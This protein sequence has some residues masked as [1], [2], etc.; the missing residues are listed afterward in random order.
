MI[1]TFA[2]N[3]LISESQVLLATGM[4]SPDDPDLYFV[5]YN[6]VNGL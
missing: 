2:I 3:K 4:D 5:Q 1:L 6:S